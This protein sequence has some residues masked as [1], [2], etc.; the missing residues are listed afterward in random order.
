MHHAFGNTGRPYF[1]PAHTGALVV[2]SQAVQLQL[3]ALGGSPPANTSWQ[4]AS[5]DP[6]TKTTLTYTRTVHAHKNIKSKGCHAFR[7]SLHDCS[8]QK[9]SL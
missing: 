9:N 3:G 1:P 5:T 7:F 2:I 6:R 8:G 4:T